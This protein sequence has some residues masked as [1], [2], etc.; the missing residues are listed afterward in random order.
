MIAAETLSFCSTQATASCAIDR[1]ASSASGTSLCT[2]VS[3]SSSR[4]RWIMS[5]PPFS[6]VAREPA[7]CSSPGLYLPVRTPW[8]MGDQTI[9]P[10]PSSWL[11]GTT[12]SSMTRQSMEYWGWFDTSGM[13]SSRASSCAAR[14][15]SER[16]SETPM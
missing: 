9:C 5:A 7:G 10:M 12:S 11:V 3:T 8:A 2:R 14:I 16:H 1:P 4:K 6:S 13:W 15:S